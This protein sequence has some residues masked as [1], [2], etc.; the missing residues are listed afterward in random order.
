MAADCAPPLTANDLPAEDIDRSTQRA[1][2]LVMAWFLIG[3][4]PIYGVAFAWARQWIYVGLLI[5]GFCTALVA[6]LVARRTQSYEAPLR[7]ITTV[8]AAALVYATLIQG[9]ALPAAGWWL[10]I[11]PFVLAAGGLHYM[12]LGMVA[13]FIGLVSVMQFAEPL[14]WLGASDAAETIGMG[15]RYAAVA[16]SELLALSLI[17]VSM[18]RRVRIAQ[19]LE[20]ARRDALESDAVKARFLANMSHEI[21]TP[22]TG[23][24][25]VADVLHSPDLSDSQ[26]RQLIEL[27]RHSA[28]TLLALVNDI[29]DISKLDA[30]KLTLESHPLDIRQLVFET[31]ELFSMQAFAKGIELSSSC[32]PNVPRG[33]LGDAVRIRQI[34]NNLVGNA[35]KFTSRGGVH[36]HV[37]L[38]PLPADTGTAAQR[39]IHLEVVDS[40]PGIAPDALKLLFRP[41]MQASE[42]VAR[43]F[44]GTGL[45]LSIASELAKL[46]GGS[47]EARSVVGDGTTFIV[48]LP[49]TLGV[50]EGIE[51]A[52]KSRPDVVVA[53]NTR[54]LERHIKAILHELKVDPVIVRHVPDARDLAACKLLLIDA[55]LLE[56]IEARTWLAEQAAAGRRVAILTPLGID[57][58]AGGLPNAQLI[59]KPVTS[60]ALETLLLDELPR[61]TPGAPASDATPH[62]LAGLRV[63]VADD[64][65]VNQ[66][67]VQAMLAE[68]GVTAIVAGDGREALASIASDVFDLVLMDVNMP[69]MDGLAATREIRAREQAQ[70]RPRLTVLAMTAATEGEEGPVC[71]AA[72]MDGFLTKP[73]SLPQLEAG[74]RRFK[75]AKNA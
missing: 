18:R 45:G 67:V 54:G 65:P 21:R 74:L 34:L 46:M 35:V 8:V 50:P 6:L 64:N 4:L 51:P 40:G 42:S 41:F 63:L 2:F 61:G 20:Q 58:V 72:G 57:S 60:R 24:I 32:N 75:P 7:A 11:L 17:I 52:T 68:L 49:F 26:R 43:E 70:G 29:L 44:G 66:I 39:W 71:I 15:R 1:V 53:V 47:V 16:G 59:F 69:Q 10:S 33:L 73:F 38:E 14:A 31:N 28:S 36:I 55:P 25:G 23:I 27:Q 22:L 5:I 37:E 56:T 3:L 9:P 13:I 62:P 48:R 30:R 12:A 19:A